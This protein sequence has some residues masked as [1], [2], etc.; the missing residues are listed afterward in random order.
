M[1]LSLIATVFLPMTFFTGVF[2]MNF[3]VD[4][5]YTIDLVNKYYGPAIFYALCGGVILLCWLLFLSKGWIEPFFV[6]YVLVRWVAGKE[7]VA[8]LRR[9]NFGGNILK[10][11]MCTKAPPISIEPQVTGPVESKSI[12]IERKNESNNKRFAQISVRFLLMYS[13]EWE[14]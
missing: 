2:G 13:K 3:T 12:D 10:Y 11:L 1:L 6:F 5:G 4:G 7:G 9:M 14:I 8:K